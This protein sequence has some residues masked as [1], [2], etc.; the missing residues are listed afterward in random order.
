MWP[1]YEGRMGIEA[2]S[3]YF[4]ITLREAVYL[5][6]PTSYD[7]D[8]DYTEHGEDIKRE[9]VSARIL[10]FLR[11]KECEP[12]EDS[13]PSVARIEEPQTVPVEVCI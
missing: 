1:T 10:E 9:A 8:C 3:L 13:S 4:G 12:E 5:F 7:D 2:V 11:L 6:D